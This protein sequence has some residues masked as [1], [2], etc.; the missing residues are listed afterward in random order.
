MKDNLKSLNPLNHR[1]LLYV[2][3][4]KEVNKLISHTKYQYFTG[5]FKQA[6]QNSKEIFRVLNLVNGSENEIILPTL[7]KT[8][9]SLC[10][11]EMLYF[12]ENKIK[13]FQSE[14]CEKLLQINDNSLVPS[15]RDDC[16]NKTFSSFRSIT[17][18]ECVEIFN[19]C[20]K[21]YLPQLDCTNFKIFS[22]NPEVVCTYLCS[23]INKCLESSKYP[24]S[25]NKGII[26]PKIKNE[27]LDR[28]A[29]ENYRP[30]V[31]SSF[32]S[33]MIDNTIFLLIGPFI[34]SENILPNFQSSY[35]KY[36]STETAVT[37]IHNDII[38]SFANKKSVAML[39]LD[40]SAAFDT[41]D[42]DTLVS[43]LYDCGF[44]D[45]ALELLKSYIKERQVAVAIG[46][47]LRIS[48]S[49]VRNCSGLH[50]WSAVFHYIHTWYKKN[51]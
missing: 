36:H 14:I 39:L 19:K 21:T 35:Q 30:L 33:K 13:K 45:G 1:A 46:K 20:K 49:E 47:S 24:E 51:F 48:S 28:D 11:F 38:K 31:K 22:Q 8:N 41:I 40:L 32:L 37:R 7:E 23:I 27:N 10:A 25:E 3:K 12:F 16:T 34:E 2:Q 43:D 9:P 4:R 5:L 15:H 26:C 29:Y 44:R 50:P 42:Q 17:V 18:K 6:G